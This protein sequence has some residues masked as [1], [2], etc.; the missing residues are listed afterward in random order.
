VS[1]SGF[2]SSSLPFQREIGCSS[3]KVS[4]KM[5]EATISE[6]GPFTREKSR[7]SQ[8]VVCAND[9]K[10]EVLRLIGSSSPPVATIHAGHRIN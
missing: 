1:R 4:L 2:L 8:K 10:E 5:N 3:S 9:E 6:P 7:T